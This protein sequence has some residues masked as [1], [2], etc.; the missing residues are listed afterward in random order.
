M[1]GRPDLR[2]RFDREA[3]AV[4]S[5]NHPHICTLHDIGSQEGI[6]IASALDAAFH[7]GVTHRDLKPANVM[8]TKSGAKLLDFG[9]A[10]IDVLGSTHMAETAALTTEGTIM[11]CIGARATGRQG[12]R[13]AHGYFCLWRSALR[14]GHRQ[15]G[16]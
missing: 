7:K 11:Q 9:L 8:F 12:R 13:R 2:E 16:V 5:L 4:S 6:D 3:R 10:R 14:N 1:A 15:E